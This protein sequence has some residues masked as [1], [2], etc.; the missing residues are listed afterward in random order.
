[1]LALALVPEG[2]NRTDAARAAGMD[3][4]TLPRLGA[5][6]QRTWCGGSEEPAGEGAPR[7]KLTAEQEAAVA[8]WIR[9]GPTLEEHKVIR[10]RLID[11]RDEIARRFGVHLHERTVGKLMARLNFSRV[12][13]RPRHPEQDPAAQEAHKKTSPSWSPPFPSTP[14]TSRS[15]SGGSALAAWFR[16]RVGT[17][18]GRT[19]RIAIVAMARKLL[20]ALWRYTETGQ[21]PDGVT[22]S[23]T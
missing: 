5:S 4:Q 10:W 19:R 22:V 12:S 1:M 7:R 13:V 9:E 21:V 11:L 14:A 23:A 16:A 20:I 6:L 8:V 18:Q 2:H 17:L 3:R 15:N